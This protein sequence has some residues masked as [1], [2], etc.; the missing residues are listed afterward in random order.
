MRRL[1]YFSLTLSKSIEF[2]EEEEKKMKIQEEEKISLN[3]KR[4]ENGKI[5]SLCQRDGASGKSWKSFFFGATGEE[6]K[7]N[8]AAIRL[9]SNVRNYAITK[10]FPP[11]VSKP[12]ASER[13]QAI[14]R[15][16]R[17]KVSQF[18]RRY[19]DFVSFINIS[20][21]LQMRFAAAGR[22]NVFAQRA[23]VKSH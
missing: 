10:I 21:G 2:D 7:T 6:G 22:V 18:S 23:T 13:W 5:Y 4:R 16:N 9:H 1:T 15:L 8:M 14:V 19:L 20:F 12:R 3:R 11:N 17:I